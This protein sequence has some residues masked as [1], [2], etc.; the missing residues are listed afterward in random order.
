LLE[1]NQV[2]R[3]YGVRRKIVGG[4]EKADCSLGT[5]G[6]FRAKEQ[7]ERSQ[8]G[9]L[10]PASDRHILTQHQQIMLAL[11]TNAECAISSSHFAKNLQEKIRKL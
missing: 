10:I 9:L 1:E 11:K 4:N 3:V 8:R 5:I 7:V 6:L 2:W